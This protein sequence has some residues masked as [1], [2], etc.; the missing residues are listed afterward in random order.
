MLKELEPL[1]QAEFLRLLLV[2]QGKPVTVRLLDPPLHE[3][4]PT[5][6]GEIEQLAE[7]TGLGLL[8]VQRRLEALREANPMMGLR[9]CRLGIIFPEIY[10][11]R[12]CGPLVAAC[13]QA[14]KQGVEPRVDIML[15]LI[16]SASEVTILRER[17]EPIAAEDARQAIGIGAMIETPRAC[18]RARRKSRGAVT[19]FRSG[20]TT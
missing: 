11:D 8:R 7:T 9:G 6:S 19:S 14:R 20:P 4:L 3:F 13:R 5:E 10:M 16:S 17:L 18:L 2:L 12:R 15:P 1:V